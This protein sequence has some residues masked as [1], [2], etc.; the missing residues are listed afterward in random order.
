M[1]LVKFVKNK[2][3][4]NSLEKLTEGDTGSTIIGVIALTLL[5]MN[6]DFDAVGLVLSGNVSP[7]GIGEVVKVAAGVSLGIWAWKTGKGKK[8]ESTKTKG[9]K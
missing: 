5:S 9:S 6:I 4:K 3:V 7:N 2:Y 8:D 1:G